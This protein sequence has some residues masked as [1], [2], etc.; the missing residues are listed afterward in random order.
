MEKYGAFN[1][2]DFYHNSSHLRENAW[3]FLANQIDLVRSTRGM[4]VCALFD[5]DHFRLLV[6]QYGQDLGQLVLWKCVQG[7]EQTPYANQAVS[8]GR[9]EF[10]AVLPT[11]G[12]EEGIFLAESI[13]NNLC[14]TLSGI[15]DEHGILPHFQIG[16]SAGVALYPLHANDAFALLSKA[17]EGL[18]LAKKQGRNLTKFPSN[19]SMTLKSNYYSSVQLQRLTMLARKTERTEASLLREALDQFLREN[20][21]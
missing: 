11:T 21:G 7:F 10:L 1:Q 3:K 8:Y 2:I 9:D 6:E 5:I 15:I 18:Y 14:Q 4:L 20:D 19:E 16:S 12:V 17:E 13:R